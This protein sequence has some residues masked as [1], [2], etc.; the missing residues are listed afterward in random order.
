LLRSGLFQHKQQLLVLLL[1]DRN[2]IQAQQCAARWFLMLLRGVLLVLIAPAS[3]CSRAQGAVPTVMQVPWSQDHGNCQPHTL[4]LL[5]SNN[6]SPRL[7][8]SLQLLLIQ[9]FSAQGTKHLT[10]HAHIVTLQLP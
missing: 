6:S 10:V 1:Q 7:L 9:A 3:A 8:L 5:C 4:T 2:T